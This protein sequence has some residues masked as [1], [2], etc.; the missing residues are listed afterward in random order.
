[1]KR[2]LLTLAVALVCVTMAMFSYSQGNKTNNKLQQLPR[3]AQTF[4]NKHFANLEVAKVK[5]EKDDGI[6]E[7]EVHFKGGNEVDFDAKGKW[8]KV[9]C[10]AAKV[11]AA[12]IP[13]K[14]AKYVA[15][16]YPGAHITEI[17][18]SSRG[19]EVELSNDLDIDFSPSFKVIKVDH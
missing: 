17:Q 1:M 10:K 8:T 7:Y 5:Y 18:R 16:N 14:I 19:Y 11:P 13:T 4:I 9:D 15:T 3:M 12:L 2:T 6:G